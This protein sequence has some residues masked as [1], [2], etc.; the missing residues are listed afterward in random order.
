VK[1][2]SALWLTLIL[3]VTLARIAMT[4]RLFSVTRD[5]PVHIAAGY[6]YLKHHTF[7]DIEQPP[8]PGAFFA[9]LLLN[10][11]EPDST[12]W[13]RR[14]NSVLADHG[15]YMHGTAKARA[16]NVVFVVIAMLALFF[17]TRDLFGDTVALIAVAIFG[18]LPPVLAHAGLATPDLAATAAFALA[19]LVYNRWLAQ[20]SWRRTALLA[21]AIAF[22]SLCSFSFLLFFLIGA[23]FLSLGS[24]RLVRS[25]AAAAALSRGPSGRDVRSPLISRAV[26][27]LAMAFVIA[28]GAYFFSIGTMKSVDRRSREW[29]RQSF[30][31]SGIERHWQVPAPA[32][33]TGILAAIH[34]NGMAEAFLLGEHSDRGWW[35]Y[36]PVT[37]AV[38]T[39]LPM[40]ALA[41]A[42]AMLAAG[43]ERHGEVAALALGLLGFAIVSH[44][45]LGI[46]HILP[47]YVPLS[48]LAAYAV[49]AGWEL[50][51]RH[52]AAVAL[53]L[54]WLIADGVLAH[55][56]YL[57]WMN[58]LA[59]PHP[60]R[61]LADSNFDWGQD[62]VRL[63]TVCRHRNIARLGVLFNAS[64]ASDQLWLPPFDPNPI[65]PYSPVN[66][67]VAVGETPLQV[68][69]AVDPN[70]Y[71][72]LTANRP[73]IRVGKTIRLYHV[74]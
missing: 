58:A 4:W 53:A 72:W 31:T 57:P 59:G 17:W 63:R 15:R 21:V 71:T 27:A 49:V 7:L 23:A 34:D 1:R 66:G 61:V 3:A 12:Q 55:P 68:N 41:V 70:S 16:G 13:I 29:L 37:L 9:L 2:S 5:E 39:P 64:A 54:L 36:F 52:R 20:P 11:P 60:E 50:S 10:Q 32:L 40:L 35:Y 24:G 42:G 74:D 45:N 48:M 67:W 19:M 18:N 65:G 25:C 30:H 62:L 8:L 51:K 26:W 43:R 47:V 46:R 6:D 44:V 38:K 14:G 69:Q 56:D 73:Y 22:G 28:W 33:F